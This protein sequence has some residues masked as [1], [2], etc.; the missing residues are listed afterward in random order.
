MASEE[1]GI[2]ERFAARPDVF[3]DL[4]V[5]VPSTMLLAESEQVQVDLFLVGGEQ[6]DAYLRVDYVS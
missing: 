5:D 2:P 1:L 6:L 3:F 4:P